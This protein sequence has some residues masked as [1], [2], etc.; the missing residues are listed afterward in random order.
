MLIA[1]GRLVSTA[2][3]PCPALD[4]LMVATALAHGL[5]R[6]KRN[7][8]GMSDLGVKSCIAWED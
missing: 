5:L 2:G 4:S 7:I 3:R 6:V 8:K 1:G